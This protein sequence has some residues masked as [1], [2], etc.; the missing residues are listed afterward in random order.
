MN[1]YEGHTESEAAALA[2]RHLKDEPMTREQALALR[3][4]RLIGEVPPDTGP[5]GPGESESGEI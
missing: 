2:R 1:C 4:A 5:T 3:G